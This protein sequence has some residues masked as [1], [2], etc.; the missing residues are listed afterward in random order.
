M[1]RLSSSKNSEEIPWMNLEKLGT[2]FTRCPLVR[3]LIH[4]NVLEDGLLKIELA[5]LI[6]ITEYGNFDVGVDGDSDSVVTRHLESRSGVHCSQSWL[7]IVFL[8]KLLQLLVV[9]REFVDGFL[10]KTSLFQS[11]HVLVVSELVG[12]IAGVTHRE[13]HLVVV[14][15]FVREDEIVQVF[16][17]QRETNI[18]GVSELE[19]V[20]VEIKSS[21]NWVRVVVVVIVVVLVGVDENRKMSQDSGLDLHQIVWMDPELEHLVAVLFLTDVVN[22][23]TRGCRNLS[24]GRKFLDGVLQRG[25]QRA[26]SELVSHE[27]VQGRDSEQVGRSVFAD[28][29]QRQRLH[30]HVQKSLNR[31]S[32]VQSVMFLD[33]LDETGE[34]ESGKMIQLLGQRKKLL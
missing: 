9:G 5:S 1:S 30:S 20:V 11:F 10:W 17:F 8:D 23:C 12:G 18:V 15:L 14:V 22:R 26:G 7:Q 6:S 32:L 24:R 19:V 21:D 2:S 25:R 31:V 27:R 3:S 4:D 16:F 29:V 34:I 28:V 13:V 33:D